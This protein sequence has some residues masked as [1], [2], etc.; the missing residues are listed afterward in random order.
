MDGMCP[1]KE[2]GS[3]IFERLLPAYEFSSSER[4]RHEKPLKLNK[5]CT[6]K[7]AEKIMNIHKMRKTIA[8]ERKTSEYGK[9][10]NIA[11]IFASARTSHRSQMYLSFSQFSH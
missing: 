8:N 5:L 3:T 11:V 10:G 1:T 9:S 7:H 6:W 2:A 4:I